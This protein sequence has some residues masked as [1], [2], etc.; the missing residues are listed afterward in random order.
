M[1]S[2][3]PISHPGSAEL[4]ERVN[5]TECNST[6]EASPEDVSRFLEKNVHSFLK[7]N[8]VSKAEFDQKS[9][10]KSIDND[11]DVQMSLRSREEN[12]DYSVSIL[13]KFQ[14]IWT[15]MMSLEFRLRPF[16]SIIFRVIL[17][18]SRLRSQ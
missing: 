7:T 11:E 6:S 14:K 13:R 17:S 5:W 16:R 2:I 1:A 18:W 4:V 15:F 12:V 3:S 9:D 10:E 8:G